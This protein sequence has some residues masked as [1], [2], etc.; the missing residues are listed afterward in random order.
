MKGKYFLRRLLVSPAVILVAAS[1]WFVLNATLIGLGAQP[2]DT[3]E[4]VW[5]LG[6]IIGGIMS[7]MLLFTNYKKGKN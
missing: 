7:I 4:G 1:A 5:Q 2:S 6:L 3:P